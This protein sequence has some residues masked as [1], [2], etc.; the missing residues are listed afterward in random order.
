[1]QTPKA[2]SA[3]DTARD[4]DQT[5]LWIEARIAEIYALGRYEQQQQLQEKSLVLDRTA[6]LQIYTAVHAYCKPTRTEQREARLYRTLQQA[7]QAHCREV[8]AYIAGQA[9]SNRDDDHADLVLS[10]Y[11]KQWKIFLETSSRVRNL[12]QSLEKNWVWRAVDTTPP[13][14]GV[15]LFPE[16]HRRYWREEVLGVNEPSENSSKI[17]EAVKRGQ[18]KL[19]E[20]QIQTLADEVIATFEDLKVV[21][22][23]GRLVTLD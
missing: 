8:S 21:L 7:I 20:G 19:S 2:P 18:Q 23:E 16:L 11:V 5:F 6:Y 17:L 15:Y 22:K 3:Q 4:P 12:F 10:M 13:Q 1:M 14:E 9:S